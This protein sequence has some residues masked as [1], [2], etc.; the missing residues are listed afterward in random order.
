MRNN[1]YAPHYAISIYSIR[2]FKT[3][4]EPFMVAMITIIIIITMIS[5]HLTS[6]STDISLFRNADPTPHSSL[7][8]TSS[9]IYKVI[10]SRIIILVDSY[11]V[12]SENDSVYS[13][14]VT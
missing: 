1:S 10:P 14:P 5:G 7:I 9:S 2:E 3:G 12:N 11:V 13:N 4:A 6:I 8:H